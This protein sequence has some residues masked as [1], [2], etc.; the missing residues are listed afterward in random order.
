MNNYIFKNIKQARIL[1]GLSQKQL[2]AKLGISNKSISA[3]ES[4]RAI[5]P[6]HTLKKMSEITK[7]PFGYFLQTDV[8]RRNAE[9][10]LRDISSKLDIIIKQLHIISKKI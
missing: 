6:V 10:D 7:K 3:Y 8:E 4:G 9:T 1:S 5:P 2:G